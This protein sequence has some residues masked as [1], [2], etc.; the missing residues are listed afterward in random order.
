MGSGTTGAIAKK[1]NRNFIGIE[2]EKFYKEV[3]ERRIREIEPVDKQ[4]LVSN[5]EKK[6]PKVPFGNLLE[7]NFIKI[8]ETIYS[9][10]EKYKAKVLANGCLLF[11]NIEGSIH[12]ISGQILNKSS[13]NGWDFWYVNREDKL[14]SID[15]LRSE[16]AKKF[17]NI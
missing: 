13:N 17:I 2:K 8:G 6:K 1:F 12:Q 3:A 9:K 15:E 10:N 14:K 5:I 16:Y 4:F 7:S 11:E